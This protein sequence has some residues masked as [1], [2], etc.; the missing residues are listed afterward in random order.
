MLIVHIRLKIK[1][2]MVP[3]T[4]PGKLVNTVA[5]ML[6]PAMSHAGSRMQPHWH[7]AIHIF[8]YQQHSQLNKSALN[9]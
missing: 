4:E 9:I 2:N 3:Q 1:D 6:A 8:V 7:I 5:H